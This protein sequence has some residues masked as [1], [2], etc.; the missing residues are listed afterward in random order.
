MDMIHRD[1]SILCITLTTS[2]EFKLTT[3]APGNLE[4]VNHDHCIEYQSMHIKFFYAHINPAIFVWKWIKDYVG[5]IQLNPVKELAEIP[6][7]S[8]FFILAPHNRYKER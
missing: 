5:N 8:S 1:Q 7:H 6:N 2:R 4:S 3:G